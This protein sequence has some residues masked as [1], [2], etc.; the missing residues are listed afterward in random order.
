MSDRVLRLEGVHNFRK[1]GAY[2]LAT[3]GKVRDGLYRS[4]QFSRATPSDIETMDGLSVRVVA[5]LRRPR[6]REAEPSHW[7]QREGVTVLAS[8]HA[9]SSEPPHL[10]F[11][12]ESDM[13]LDSIRGFMTQTYRRLPFDPGNQ[14][15]FANGLRQLADSKPEDGFI[16]HCAAGK[17]RTGLF[18]A[19]LLTALGVDEEMVREDYLMTN[20]A[21]DFDRLV[22]AVGKRLEETLGKK[23]GHEELRAFLGVDPVYYDAAMEAIGDQR[24]YLRDALGLEDAVIERLRETL[25][26]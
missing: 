5:D 17:D 2:D 6:E 11:L 14:W 9:G 8:D 26:G 24:A 18:C 19:L 25:T 1:F 10:V 3:G 22:P 12:R 16:V 13:S 4:G 15:V 7:P 20:T 21:V 23:T